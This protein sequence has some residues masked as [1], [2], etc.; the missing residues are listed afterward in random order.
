[1]AHTAWH[2]VIRQVSHPFLTKI[3]DDLIIKR[4]LDL[5][6]DLRLADGQLYLYLLAQDCAVE[7]DCATLSTAL[8]RDGLPVVTNL[9]C[10]G[11]S[12]TMCLSGR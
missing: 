12:V 8:L 5:C 7:C 3:G 11:A 6:K 9:K 2:L 10:C 1:M 4:Q